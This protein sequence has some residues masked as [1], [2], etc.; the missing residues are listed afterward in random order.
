[1]KRAFTLI[2]LLVV[3][4]IIAILAAIL[5]PVFATA[6]EKA[7]QTACLS[8]EKQLGIALIQYFQ[9]YDEYAVPGR[10][11]YGTGNCWAG[12]LYPYIKSVGVFLCPSDTQSGDICSYAYNCNFVKPSP[13]AW[14]G[15]GTGSASGVSI[16][17]LANPAKTVVFAEVT[18][19]GGFDI[20]TEANVGNEFNG[21]SPTG[22]GDGNSND[23]KGG[24]TTSSSLK[25]ATGFL[26]DPNGTYHQIAYFTGV[27]GRHNNGANY[28]FADGHTKWFMPTNVAAGQSNTSGDCGGYDTAASTLCS[29]IP[30]TFSIN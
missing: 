21:Y 30:A 14:T 15:P 1:M 16:S 5:F 22:D 24:A 12:I 20:T 9:D 25:W 11:P 8:N 26:S 29:S 19:A 4:A 28:I 10:D 27:T 3:I 18:G 23:P 17:S 2:E 7:R 6:R 13:T